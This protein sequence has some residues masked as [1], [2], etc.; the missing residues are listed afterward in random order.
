MRFREPELFR[1][2]QLL[3]KKPPFKILFLVPAYV[4]YVQSRLQH[5]YGCGEPPLP[6]PVGKY[7]QIL[8]GG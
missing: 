5:F 7:N 8:V 4:L 3:K 2:F 6:G 1:K